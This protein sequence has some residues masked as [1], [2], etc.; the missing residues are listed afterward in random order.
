VVR[1]RHG[2]HHGEPFR[3]MGE[4]GGY[5]CGVDIN[6]VPEAAAA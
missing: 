6:F 2:R 4:T 1:W 3:A 5:W